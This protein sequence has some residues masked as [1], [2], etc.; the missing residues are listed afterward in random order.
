MLVVLFIVACF[1]IFGATD[2]TLL[3]T[4]MENE[5]FSSQPV[6]SSSQ[7]SPQVQGAASPANT[8]P[9]RP[10]S[11][12]CPTEIKVSWQLRPP[13]TVENNSKQDQPTAYGIFHRA[14][15]FALEKCCLFYG[16]NKPILR[17]LTMSDN[18]SA[19]Q[20][21]TFTEDASLAFP[22]QRDWYIGRG[23]HYI[24]ILDSPGVVII[25]KGPSYST[26][27]KRYQLFEAILETWPVVVLSL[28][29][30]YLAGI[31]IWLL[32]GFPQLYLK[33]AD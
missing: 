8:R 15:D 3:K 26:A 17:Y 28:L 32:V 1:E 25:R 5:L 23:R 33:W 20:H 27:E 19:L 11:S 12:I 9:S 6:Q 22:I 7:S 16:G 14:L 30:S 13:Y 29:M 18:A 10:T 24:N 31:C 4:F 2:M 21:T